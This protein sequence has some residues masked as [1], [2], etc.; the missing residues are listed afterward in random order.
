MRYGVRMKRAPRS[1]EAKRRQNQAYYERHR[2]RILED[3]RQKY[4]AMKDS[5]PRPAS[6]RTT[7]LY[8]FFDA[9]GVLVY[10]GITYHFDVRLTQHRNRS[11][12]F[13]TVD[14]WTT[15]EYPSRRVAK[16]VETQAIREE[17][18]RFNQHESTF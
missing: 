18:P 9:D 12:W 10:V 14:R 3:A 7:T 13:E 15:E 16:R 2:A 8:R 5:R 1:P 11:R 4:A 17:R 6:D